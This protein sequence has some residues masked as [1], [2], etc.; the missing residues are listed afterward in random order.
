M[1]SRLFTPGP[2]PV[3][4]HVMLRMAQPMIHHRTE[5]FQQVLADVTSGL[6]YL[7]CTEQPVFVLT[8]SGTGAME[9]AVV[10]TMSAGD[11][12]ITVDGGKF[13]ERW[14]N[15]ADAYGL[16]NHRIAVEWGT[17][18]TVERI[19]ETLE[20]NP[21]VQAICLTHSE[22]S[23][24]VFTD[25]R[26]I[27]SRIRPTFDGLILVD[28]ITAVGAHEMRF[29]AWDLDVVVTGSQKGLMIPPGLA[30]I[31]LSERAWK[32]TETS[33]LPRF[34]F[35]LIEARTSLEQG[36][37]PWTP[38]ITLVLGLAE[39]LAM[40]RAEGR[41]NVWARHERLADGLRQGMTALGF[42]LF[43]APPSN[44]VTSVRI[45]EGGEKFQS[46]MKSRYGITMAG[47]QEDLKGKIFRVS[48]L[49]YYD[50]GDMLAFLHYTERALT[51]LGLPHEPGAGVSAAQQ[52]FMK[53]LTSSE[54]LTS[55]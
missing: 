53:H 40:I 19:A 2:T 20:R 50:E 37:T 1:R 41:E 17:A 22:T 43:G 6:Q 29:D 4:E 48:H 21:G 15:I 32:K 23:T 8:A 38:A 35:D 31:A 33:N 46:V 44:A 30:F 16:R 27:A 34:Y 14:G 26:E 52:V 51:D 49:G 36:D 28:G 24:G 47:G 39:S 42:E 7:F 18:V 13:G 9:A 11:E 10:N 5:E 55:S 3:P 45:P 54:S 25:V 12:V